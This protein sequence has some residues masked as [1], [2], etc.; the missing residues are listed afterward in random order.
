MQ[1]QKMKETLDRLREL[2]EQAQPCWEAIGKF[3]SGE[4]VC[5]GIH[6]NLLLEIGAR[7]D[8]RGNV[9][10]DT[11]YEVY[12]EGDKI[13]VKVLTDPGNVVCDGNCDDCPIQDTDCDEDCAH[14]PCKDHC[15]DCEV[16]A[17]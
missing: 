6:K 16:L 1:D 8:E 3:A 5:L 10:E 12:V 11:V 9:S 13:V 4:Y 17:E 15:E 7:P 2:N 14:C